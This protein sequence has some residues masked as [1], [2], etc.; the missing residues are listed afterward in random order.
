MSTDNYGLRSMQEIDPV[1]MRMSSRQW[2]KLGLLPSG[3]A[4]DHASPNSFARNISAM[5]QITNAVHWHYW[6]EFSNASSTFRIVV[7]GPQMTYQDW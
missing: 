6:V 1:N 7:F 4:L 5:N 2:E 3:K